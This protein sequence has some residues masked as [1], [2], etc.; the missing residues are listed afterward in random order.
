MGK[1]PVRLYSMDIARKEWEQVPG[2]AKGV[3]QKILATDPITG[4]ITRLG[5]VE[6][7]VEQNQT[8]V[9]DHWEEVHILE[10]SKKIGEEFHP[11]GTY[12]CKPPQVEHGPVLTEDGFVQIEFMDYHRAD[13]NKPLIRLY[14]MDIQR[15]P[16]DPVEGVVQGIYIKSLAQDPVTRSETVLMRVDAGVE[17]LAAVDEREE[18]IFILEGSCRIGEEFY[19]A[20]TYTCRPPG[21]EQGP[22]Y[23]KEG[24][25][26]LRVRNAL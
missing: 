10:G 4:S 8:W 17:V 7:Q 2:A 21:I 5:K 26:A 16:W 15:L 3:M 12:T 22:L 23:T 25:L 14:P 11:V 19:P 18:E 9:H 1:G 13:M 6:P 24:L 20:G